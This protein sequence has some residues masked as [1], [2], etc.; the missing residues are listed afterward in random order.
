MAEILKFMCMVE[1]PLSLIKKGFQKLLGRDINYIETYLASEGFIAFQA[2]QGV[3]SMRLVLNNGSFYEFIPF[4]DE[5]F[6]EDGNMLENPKTLMI[7]EVE[8]NVEYA[9]LISTC[10]GAW[11]YLIG[12]TIKFVSKADSEIVITGRTKH[13]LSLC[14]EHLFGG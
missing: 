1:W 13:F 10:S 12:D 2:N 11:R 14:G 7:D 4:P 3:D 6:D 8:E 5:N 9:L